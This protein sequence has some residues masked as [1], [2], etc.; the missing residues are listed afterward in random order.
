[1]SFNSSTCGVCNGSQA[2][3]NKT[4]YE[5]QGVQDQGADRGHGKTHWVNFH[6]GG[7]CGS[8]STMISACT[9]ADTGA[10]PGIG[11]VAKAGQVWLGVPGKMEGLLVAAV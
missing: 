5:G 11:Y 2:A 1:V 3:R 8:P 9:G 4:G 6:V 10:C 7:C